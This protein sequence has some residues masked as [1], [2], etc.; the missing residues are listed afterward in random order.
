MSASRRW[1][2]SVIPSRTPSGARGNARD[3]KDRV[4]AWEVSLEGT[5]AYES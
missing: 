5:E 4:V 2:F 1:R 3:P